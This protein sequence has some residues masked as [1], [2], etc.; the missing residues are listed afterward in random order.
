MSDV[1][2]PVN[3]PSLPVT[4][5]NAAPGASCDGAQCPACDTAAD[6]STEQVQLPTTRDVTIK[7]PLQVTDEQFDM[8]LSLGSVASETIIQ[9]GLVC[10]FPTSAKDPKT[11]QQRMAVGHAAMPILNAADCQRVLKLIQTITTENLKVIQ[12]A[13]KNEPGAQVEAAIAAD[14]AK[15]NATR[16]AGAKA[17]GQAGG[18]IIAQ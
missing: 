10:F 2:P 3:V 12:A 9:G 4:E 5:E 15:D 13:R 11:Q 16:D 8:A 17:Q 14:V 6:A 18:I 1:T 7:V